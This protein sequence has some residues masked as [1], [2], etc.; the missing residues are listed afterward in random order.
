MKGRCHRN[1]SKGVCPGIALSLLA[2]PLI[3]WMTKVNYLE[4]FYVED[5]PLPQLKKC[6]DSKALTSG[7]HPCRL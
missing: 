7:H 2:L 4:F 5:L 1:H 3:T 6:I